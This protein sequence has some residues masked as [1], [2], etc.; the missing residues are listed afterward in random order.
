MYEA[1]TLGN[2]GLEPCESIIHCSYKNKIDLFI[3]RRATVMQQGLTLK[4]YNCG[5]LIHC[6]CNT[7]NQTEIHLNV[8]ERITA[9]VY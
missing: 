1:G 6:G 3:G 7:A 4:S 5:V 8:G 2:Q 9:V